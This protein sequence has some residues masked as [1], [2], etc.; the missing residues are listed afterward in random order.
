V[1]RAYFTQTINSFFTIL[2]L[3]VF[4]WG[5]VASICRIQPK[6]GK[7]KVPNSGPFE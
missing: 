4:Q 2:G 6:L 3:F 1:G 5:F 7:S